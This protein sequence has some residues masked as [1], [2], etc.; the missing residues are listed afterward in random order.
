MVSIGGPSWVKLKLLC[1]FSITATDIAF[2][3][4]SIE[5]VEVLGSALYNGVMFDGK[6]LGLQETGMQ[7]DAVSMLRYSLLSYAL[8]V[9]SLLLIE[10]ALRSMT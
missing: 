10:G 3:L 4:A 2:H 1:I 5:E 6:K 7:K 9:T 8:D